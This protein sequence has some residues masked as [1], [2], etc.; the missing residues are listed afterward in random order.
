MKE[1]NTE[2]LFGFSPEMPEGLSKESILEK[3]EKNNIRPKKPDAKKDYSF[4]F[5]V[6][7]FAVLLVG[8]LAVTGS[9]SNKAP[10]AQKQEGTSQSIA[11]QTEKVPVKPD[12]VVSE[13]LP[14]G[15][16]TFESR[17]Q[18]E[19]H[20]KYAY[21]QNYYLYYN[22]VA[23][24]FDLED[25]AI[26]N[27]M[28]GEA[29]SDA[30]ADAPGSSVNGAYGDYTGT[31][32]QNG[33]DEGDVIKTDGRYLYIV[34]YVNTVSYVKIV[35]TKDMKLL[36]ELPYDNN[37]G[38][39]LSG[40]IYING[41]RLVVLYNKLESLKN[42]FYGEFIYYDYI[43]GDG[44]TLA[45]IYDISDKTKPEKL[46]TVSQSGSVISTRMIGNV[47]YTVT[48]YYDFPENEDDDFYCVPEVNGSAVD[49]K[50]IIHF[51]EDKVSAYTVITATDITDEKSERGSLSILTNST[52][53]YC[54]EENL[55]LA[56]NTYNEK[57]DKTVITKISLDGT[58]I[59]CE[60]SGEVSG[61]YND[62]YSFDESN[63][64]LRL[65]TTAYNY[66]TFR[67]VCSLYILDENL[68]TV[69]KIDDITG[70]LDEE[71][72]AVRFMGEK[73]Y[74]VTFEQTDP[75]FVLDLSDV[76]NPSVK[77][78]LFM[79]GYS[80]YLHPV[81]DGVLLG[82]GY[83]G[84]ENSE[85]MSKLKIALYDV[86]DMNNPK[87]LDEFIINNGYTDVNYDAKA[88]IHFPAKNIVGIPVTVH[89]YNGY[90][91]PVRS[92]A[93][94][95]YEGDK[96]QSVSGFVHETESEYYYGGF[97]RGTCIGDYLYTVDTCAV[98]EHRLYDGEKLRECILATD[99][100][101]YPEINIEDYKGDTVEYTVATSSAYIP[102]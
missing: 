51:D 4:A 15:V 100:E 79:P 14:E 62:K 6:A 66:E 20:F 8:A 92:F 90:G 87:I 75:L 76:N 95:S 102:E 98:I 78:K 84:D 94:I 41:D 86:S 74:V 43:G 49:C 65:V 10:V 21:E 45:D 61:C 93:I 91:N 56:R 33:A 34:T 29:A 40:E 19:A 77:G 67:Q 97:F 17:E 47:L 68:E 80:T 89:S 71:V 18:V 13:E 25:G 88:L 59:R 57:G 60:A 27:E 30:V 70:G 23:D 5:V 101:L 31:N 38:Y 83:G 24:A 11:Q 26:K 69:S 12:P 35:D 32:T 85:D 55:Y 7:L 52:G 82:I 81:R 44:E 1:K 63:G 42:N 3:I 39:N 37:E 53:M 22:T 72:K 58:S 46:F 16:Y 64:Y 48:R 54:S 99:E 9:F 96:L 2:N 50:E 73:A 28:A 36:C